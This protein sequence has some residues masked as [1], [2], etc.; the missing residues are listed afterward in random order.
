[1][2]GS[3]CLIPIHL[4]NRST[5]A[6]PTPPRR[7]SPSSSSACAATFTSSSPSLPWGRP[8]GTHRQQ[9]T[10]PSSA[11]TPLPSPF[12]HPNSVRARHFPALVNCAVVDV[13]HPWPREALVSVAE[14]GVLEASVL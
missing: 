4:R 3:T 7:S 6:S 13:F 12:H 9:Q 11:P 8:S 2:E 1:M 10:L 5:R 14:V